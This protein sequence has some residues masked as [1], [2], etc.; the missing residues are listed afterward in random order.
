MTIEQA[1]KITGIRQHEILRINPEALKD[2]IKREKA[3]RDGDYILKHYNKYEYVEAYERL[4]H[5][6]EEV[7]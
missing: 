1:C 4:L 3:N 7:K 2:I 6:V 5:A